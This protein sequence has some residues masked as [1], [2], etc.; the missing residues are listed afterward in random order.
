MRAPGSN[1]VKPLSISCEPQPG[2]TIGIVFAPPPRLASGRS[3]GRS[4]LAVTVI[5]MRLRRSKS[6]VGRFRE[7]GVFGDAI[8]Q[9]RGE[10][11]GAVGD[12]FETEIF[13]PLLD[14]W[15]PH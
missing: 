5:C 13:Q 2:V 3:P 11:R 15:R 9:S 7:L 8:L 4:T 6:D 1:I 12:D 10:L 14:G